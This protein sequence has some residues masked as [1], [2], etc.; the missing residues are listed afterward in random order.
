MEGVHKEKKLQLRLKEM[1]G[2]NRNYK[3]DVAKEN[4]A[5]H[6]PPLRRR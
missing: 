4:H 3:A 5:A 6:S 1:R 2:K